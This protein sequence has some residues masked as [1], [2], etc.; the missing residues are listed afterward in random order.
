MKT[1]LNFIHQKQKEL[2]FGCDDKQLKD[3]IGSCQEFEDQ[4]SE[5]NLSYFQGVCT[6]LSSLVELAPE[7]RSLIIEKLD[8]LSIIYYR[9]A[10]NV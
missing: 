10:R 2:A 1:F 8:S 5:S 9:S 6:I 3:L 7:D 4:I